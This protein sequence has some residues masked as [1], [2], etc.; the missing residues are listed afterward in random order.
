MGCAGARRGEMKWSRGGV[1]GDLSRIRKRYRGRSGN[2]N[3][4]D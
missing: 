2:L 1:N 3:E 4:G